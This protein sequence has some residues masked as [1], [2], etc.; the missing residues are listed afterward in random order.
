MFMFRTKGEICSLESVRGY[1]YQCILG[2]HK[3]R[4]K[5]TLWQVYPYA[6]GAGS[7]LVIDDTFKNVIVWVFLTV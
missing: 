3:R 7:H 4:K 2:H 5:K 1:Q 6:R